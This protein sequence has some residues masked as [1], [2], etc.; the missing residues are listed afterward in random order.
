MRRKK[1]SYDSYE[2]NYGWHQNKEKKRK[3]KDEE[4]P[5]AL[6]LDIKDRVIDLLFGKDV[7]T[8]QRESLYRYMDEKFEKCCS[9]SLY[10]TDN[11]RSLN[12][13][14]KISSFALLCKNLGLDCGRRE[15]Q[16]TG[17][18][19]LLYSDDYLIPCRPI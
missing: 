10:I 13:P 19:C 16:I 14:D 15:V 17:K 6:T 11:D 8:V 9:L 12:K 2:F 3:K 7:N 18:L 1:D 5:I 4:K